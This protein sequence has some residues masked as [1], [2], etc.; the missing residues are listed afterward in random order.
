[1]SLAV[2]ILKRHCYSM[3]KVLVTD[4][5]EGFQNVVCTKRPYTTYAYVF[6]EKL[7]S[8]NVI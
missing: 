7:N 2:M 6:E 1:M 4:G 5:V 8:A 3:F